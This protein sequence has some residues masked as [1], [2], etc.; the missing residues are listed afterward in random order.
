MFRPASLLT[1]ALVATLA[2]APL[3]NAGGHKHFKPPVISIPDFKIPGHCN[4]PPIVVPPI[5]LPR[6]PIVCPPKRPIVCPKPPIVCPPRPPI[7]CPP[8]VVCPPRPP[9][10]CPPP[11][12]CPPKPPVICPPPVVCPP[13]PPV[14]CPPPVIKPICHK[15]VCPPVCPPVCTC[16]NWYFGMSLQLTDSHYGRGMQVTSVTPGSP[17]HQ[18]GLQ[19]GDILYA[20]NHTSLYNAVS[21]EHGVQIIQSQVAETQSPGYGHV[22]LTSV[23]DADTNQVVELT[24]YPTRE[25]EEAPI[26]TTLTAMTL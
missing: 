10:I 16:D 7:V 4:K 5:T 23:W 15:P 3:A 19:P 18:A 1:L 25:V 14:V 24:V 8:P 17:A 2:A 26:P 22:Q 20:A 11:V 21:N 12:V 13:A 6:P 9:V